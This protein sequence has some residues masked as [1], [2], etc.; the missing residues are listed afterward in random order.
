[1]KIQIVCGDRTQTI[2]CTGSGSFPVSA[3][4]GSGT[5]VMSFAVPIID[6]HGFWHPD[7]RWPSAKLEWTIDFIAAAN[8]FWPVLSFFNLHGENRGT[9]SVS[10]LIDDCR[11][12]A[13]MN[14][15][16]CCY[17]VTIS[18]AVP[19]DRELDFTLWLDF[20]AGKWQDALR[21]A[22]EHSE[23]PPRPDYPAAAWLPVFCTWYAVHACVTQKWVEN[24]AKCAAELGFG[25]FIVDDGWCFD[26]MRRSTPDNTF[27]WYESIGDWEVSTRKFPDFRAHLKRVKAMGL[28]YILWVTPFLIGIRSRVSAQL[29]PDGVQPAVQSGCQVFNPDSEAGCE[30]MK[31]KLV[32][33]VR[34]YDIAGLKID[35]IDKPSPSLEHPCGRKIMNFIRGLTDEMRTV[36]PDILIEFR[37]AYS[38]QAMRGCATQFRAADVPLDWMDNFRRLAKMHMEL[39]DG[40]PIH[41]DPAYWH[42]DEL[43]ENI[44]RHMIAALSGVPMLSM[45]LGSIGEVPRAIVR[46]WLVF[47]RKHLETFRIGHWSSKY[48][49]ENLCYASVSGNSERIVTLLDDAR[50]PEVMKPGSVILNLSSA[51]L[52]IPDSQ[53][54]DCMGN[55]VPGRAP[56]GGY[57]VVP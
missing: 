57:A 44:S 26:E 52:N 1:M 10:D 39:G 42:P 38:Q 24:T 5:A 36:R 15:T 51:E 56:V 11:I 34:E 12:N 16:G 23:R 19:E 53:G 14:Q 48:Y 21:R 50:L 8:R 6:M 46:H 29:G 55:P 54:F 33:L 37:E 41:A 27:R 30:I 2:E 49:G 18:V 9:F 40:V 32:R 43:P 35:F 13:K 45:D 20:E 7:R 4:A 17:D 28:N 47:Y 22:I 31:E 25:N 3:A